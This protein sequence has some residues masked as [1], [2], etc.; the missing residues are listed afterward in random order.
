MTWAETFRRMWGN[1]GRS[2]LVA[3]GYSTLATTILIGV[4]I[5]Q[6]IP[7]PPYAPLGPYPVQEVESPVVQS[8][9]AV[10][11]TG[12]KCV[13]EAVYVQGEAHFRRLT[14]P[15]IIIPLFSGSRYQVAGCVTRLFENQLPENMTVG[16]WIVEGSD[17]VFKGDETQTIVW[18]SE[19]FEVVDGDASE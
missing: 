15:T 5:W 13:K 3:F 11:I 1:G 6:L 19:P 8:G 12:T 2:V 14:G 10:Y 17:T 16:T 9:T 4:L 7:N 18:N